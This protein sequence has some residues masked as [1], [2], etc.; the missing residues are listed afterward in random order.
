[1]PNRPGNDDRITAD[2]SQRDA[3]SGTRTRTASQGGSVAHP[4]QSR[5]RVDG[6]RKAARDRQQGR[7]GGACQGHGARIRLRRSARSRPQGRRGGEPQSR[8]HGGDRPSWRRSARPVARTRRRADEQRRQRQQR[9]KAASRTR[10]R[11]RRARDRQVAIDNTAANGVRANTPGQARRQQLARWRASSEP[12]R[13]RRRARAQRELREPLSTVAN[14]GAAPSGRCPDRRDKPRGRRRGIPRFSFLCRRLSAIFSNFAGSM[15]PPLTTT[16]AGVGSVANLREPH[17]GRRARA[18]AFDAL[19]CVFHS[20]AIV[21]ARSRPRSPSRS[22]RA[23]AGRCRTPR[24]RSGRRVHRRASA[25]CRSRRCVPPRSTS[26]SPP[27]SR[28]ARRGCAPSARPRA[29]RLAHPPSNPPPPTLTTSDREIRQVAEDLER[30]RALAGEQHVAEARI[31]ERRAVLARR[32]LSPRPSPR[33]SAAATCRASR[34]ARR[35][36]RASP[37]AR[38]MGTKIV[39]GTPKC[40]AAYAT[41]SP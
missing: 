22:R 1:M 35:C 29:T 11:G 33:R 3:S 31:D 4:Q 27:C 36:R 19:P 41:P 26:T 10:A 15:L 6:S 12:R 13:Q 2:G 18:R 5:L 17:G 7:S 9:A 21:V 37:A 30:D 25:R 23:R 14:L 32:T 28:S 16:A 20:H 38:S 40:F 34:R 24:R 39:A 8:A